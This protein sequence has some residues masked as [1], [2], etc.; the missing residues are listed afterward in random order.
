MKYIKL[1][2]TVFFIFYFL[3][4]LRQQITVVFCGLITHY[5]EL[6]LM[7]VLMEIILEYSL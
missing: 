1:L 6:L 3:T 2:P 5:P 7:P 4:M